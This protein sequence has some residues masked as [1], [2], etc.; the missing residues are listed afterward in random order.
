MQ[1][2]NQYGFALAT[3]RYT[4]FLVPAHSYCTYTC[5]TLFKDRSG[6]E[7]G[8]VCVCIYVCECMTVWI[9]GRMCAC[10]DKSVFCGSGTGV[11][12]PKLFL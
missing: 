4:H 8:N 6:K 5:V 11:T 7:G 12:K 2:W 10:V 9:G 1:L 3:A